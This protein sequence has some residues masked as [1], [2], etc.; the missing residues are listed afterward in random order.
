MSFLGNLRALL[1]RSKDG[2]AIL[3]ISYFL[4]TCIYALLFHPGLMFG[5]I[6]FLIIPGLY[7]VIRYWRRTYHAFL[8]SIVAGVATGFPLQ[9]VADLNGVWH[10]EFPLFDWMTFGGLRMIPL[11]WYV[12]WIGLTVSAYSVFFDRHIHP[13]RKT[14]VFWKVHYKFLVLSGAVVSASIYFLLAHPDVFIF[15]YPYVVAASILF[16]VPTIVILFSH[17]QLLRDT[18]KAA[19]IL[20]LLMLVYELVGLKIGW[21]SYPGEY[22]ASIPL[23]G[24]VLPIEEIVLWVFFG[25]LFCV[26]AYEEVEHDRAF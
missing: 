12:L 19:G 7:L 17:P 25:A 3:V 4:G 23:F 11:V 5:H 6:L 10:Y 13:V 16:I 2:D 22:I 15:P 8:F 18:I 24:T 1:P 9:I 21:W 26:V 14:H 20:S